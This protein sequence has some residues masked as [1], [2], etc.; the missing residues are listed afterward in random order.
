MGTCL[1]TDACHQDVWWAMVHG[2][3]EV[4]EWYE[5]SG[6]NAT[7][8]FE[9]VQA[10]LHQLQKGSREEWQG[11]VFHPIPRPCPSRGSATVKNE[12]LHCPQP[13]LEPA[14]TTTTTTT[15]ACP[16]SNGIVGFRYS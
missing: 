10:F 2:F 6:V 3:A 7:S 16:N 5:G 14:A 11:M 12:L 15:E 13:T 4:P 9:E 8:C 1:E